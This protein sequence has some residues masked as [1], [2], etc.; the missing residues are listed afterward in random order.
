MS[1]YIVGDLHHYCNV[2]LN[3][4]SQI[5]SFVIHYY[6][7]TFVLEG[8]LI[9]YGDGEK[10]ILNSGDAIFFPPGTLRSREELFG[11]VSYVS[12]NFDTFDNIS[13]PFAPFLTNC[14][15]QEIRRLVS[16]YPTS[17]LSALFYSKEKCMLMLNYILLELMNNYSVS[18]QNEHIHKILKYIDEHINEQLSLRIISKEINL[19]REYTSYI[20][21]KEMST[22][23]TDYINE[24]K[25]LLAK[26]LISRQN[27]TLSQVAQHISFDNYNYFCRLFKKHFG[28][29][30]G[31]YMRS[32]N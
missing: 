20:F 8:T 18:S 31:Q 6:D 7:F 16:V 30:P 4:C 17:H 21:K 2:T 23:L 26:E 5:P 9:Y 28:I 25:L 19:S 32:L 22:T 14:I 1:P 11:T 12:F 13:L 24:R 10:Y 15:N 27:M 29:S 3:H